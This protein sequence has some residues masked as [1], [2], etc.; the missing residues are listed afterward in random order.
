MSSLPLKILIVEDRAEDAELEIDALREAGFVPDWH[1]VE[2]EADYLAHLDSSLDVILA[3]YSLP[4]FDGLSALK[5]AQVRQPD[6][7]FILISG[8]IGEE[9]AVESLKLGATDFVLKQR[10]ERLA[11]A[12]LRALR[13][14]E[15]R[16]KRQQAERTL[17]EERNLLRAVIDLVPDQIY[18]KN[19]QS[20]FL[21]MN[22][23]TMRRNNITEADGFIG[24]TDFDILPWEL[25]EGFYA[26]EQ[27]LMRSGVPI[28]NQEAQDPRH[29]QGRWFINSK[30]PLH[31]G[32]GNI[33][34]LVG[35]SRDITTQ[36][37]AEEELR[38]SEATEREQRELAEA[39]RDTATAL[40]SSLE[41][42][43]VMRE[44][45][46]NLE[47][48]IPHQTANIM[49]IEGSAVRIAYWRGYAEVT[50]RLFESTRFSLDMPILRQM[51]STHAPVVT[52][53]TLDS[54]DWR[55][56]PETSW[57]RANASVPIQ[58]HGEVIGFLSVDSAQPGAFTARHAERLKAFS[59]QAAI[60]LENAQL[61]DALRRHAAE[62]ESRVAQRTAE[63]RQALAH[64]KEL[65]EL[66]SRFVSMASHEF[67]TPLTTI[68]G[69]VGLLDLGLD[70]MS[71]EQRRKHFAKIQNA[72]KHM[73]QLL[74][75][76]LL[77]GKGEAGHMEFNPEG[78]QLTEFCQ[79]IVEELQAAAENA[80]RLVYQAEGDC[81]YVLADRKLLRQILTNLLSNALKYSPESSQ[82]HFTLLCDVEE[83]TFRVQDS[84]RGI[85]QADR[86][87]LFEAFHRARN[88]G[89]VPGTGL[90]LAITK[91][92]V[93]LH[94]GTIQVESEEGGAQ[95]LS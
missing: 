4:Y 5:I 15:E 14:A 9:R 89:N 92:A 90:G 41:P 7:P 95:R 83:T 13:E 46:K 32:Q 44:I 87:H 3:D 11:P 86:P 76:V 74:D 65:N 31:D 72:V 24:K 18:V 21:L 49:L 6:V 62:L 43:V 30:V 84:G 80:T 66:K 57:I 35:T 54:P 25:A 69:S 29:W 70:K 56:W 94:G 38:R 40:A 73:T 45:L 34:G 71:A 85:P 78:V 93:D 2:T 33:V 20:Q 77:F 16:H 55:P 52:A 23:A 1:R 22:A 10:L 27:T 67:R 79:A 53:D 47:R 37:Q 60:A 91:Q 48:V 82:V 75:D 17:A 42:D 28:L 19:A 50:Q 39:L 64:E 68:L 36:K 12:V 63:L 58:A 61:Y 59:D 8:T 51:L 88:V 26:E 81:G